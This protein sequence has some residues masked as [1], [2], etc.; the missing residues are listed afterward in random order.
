MRAIV[1]A[2]AITTVGLILWKARSK[3]GAEPATDV[4]AIDA[5]ENIAAKRI[6][7]GNIRAKDSNDTTRSLLSKR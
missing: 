3:S 6:V 7:S 1:S 5:C 2:D 4:K